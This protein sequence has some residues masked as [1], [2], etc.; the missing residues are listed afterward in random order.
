MTRPSPTPT[1]SGWQKEAYSLAALRRL[2][3]R[4]LPRPVFD[5]ADGGAEDE[6]TLR[7]NEAAFATWELLPRPLNGAAERDLSLE[8]LGRQLSMPVL[9]GPTGLSGLFCPSGEIAAARAA[10]TAG[11]AIC[12]SHASTCTMEEFAR[13]TDATRWMQIFVYRDRGFT[14]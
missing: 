4:R 7:R 3:H 9:I 1:R 14:R 5:F 2:A 10:V 8:L 12:L 6:Y 11:T 13:A